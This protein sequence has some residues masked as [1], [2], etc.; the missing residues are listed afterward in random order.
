MNRAATDEPIVVDG[1]SFRP[2]DIHATV[3]AEVRLPGKR[4]VISIRVTGP[5]GGIRTCT[6]LI[7]SAE[8][9][10]IIRALGG[11][12]NSTEEP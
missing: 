12:P 9:E 4:A 11:T 3:S 5:R 10:A 7:G 6:A 1:A 8:R 2:S